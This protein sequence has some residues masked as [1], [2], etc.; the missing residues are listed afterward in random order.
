MKRMRRVLVIAL[1][2]MLAP[3]A[4]S[5][6]KYQAAM[7]SLNLTAEQRDLLMEMIANQEAADSVA[8]NR[9]HYSVYV[10]TRSY[11]DHIYV[12]WAPDEYVPWRILNYWGYSVVRIHQTKKDLVV[13][14]LATVK[15]LTLE[16]FMEAYEVNDTLAAAA[17]QIIYGKRTEFGNTEAH[18]GS[19]GSIVELMEEQQMVYSYAMLIAEKRRDIAVSMALAF[20]DRTA[21]PKQEYD[22]VVVPLVPDSIIPVDRY[23][24]TAGPLGS[25]KPEKLRTE[26]TDS[27]KAPANVQLYWPRRQEYTAFDIERRYVSR[28]GEW[29]KLNDKPYIMMQQPEA[30]ETGYN[31]YVDERV[32]PGSYEYRI[33]GY[34]MFGDLTAPCEPH[35]VEMPDLIPPSAPLLEFIEIVRDPDSDHID[36]LLHIVKD[37]IEE[38]LVGYIPFYQ[39]PNYKDRINIDI[40]DSVAQ[41]LN[42]DQ[43][44]LLNEGMMIPLVKNPVA[45]GDTIIKVDV[46]GLESG[47]LVIAATDTA[48]NMTISMPLPIHIHDL[49]PPAPPT[50]LRAAMDMSGL[51]MMNWRPSTSV[52]IEGYEIY[53]ANDLDHP[54][55]QHPGFYSADTMFVDT[56]SMKTAEPY[57]YYYVKARDYAGNGSVPSDTLQVERLTIVPPSVCRIDTLWMTP[58]TVNMKWYPA[59]EPDIL[60]YNVFRRMEGEQD[61]QLTRVL[62]PDSIAD[63]RLT[64]VDSPEP[65]MTKRYYYAIETINRS[66]LSSGM[67]YATSFLFK[68]EVV[69]PIEIKLFSNFNE[70][71]KKAQL[72]W[73]IKGLTEAV[74]KDAYLVI[75]RKRPEDEFFRHFK[76]VSVHDRYTV[77]NALRP[78]QEAQYE[79]RLRTNEGRF[80]PYSNRVMIKNTEKVEE[81]NGERNSNF[82]VQESESL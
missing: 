67:S 50:R 14:T 54:F 80:S 64:I 52:D 36:A 35:R 13:D 28:G 37:S 51:M 2:V 31:I 78:G 29:V 32:H 61:W 70:E 74:A 62:T 76:S 11:D 1:A 77:D 65:H 57:R 48:L 53:W 71:T 33:K 40:P 30:H 66:G 59:S 24:A 25:W 47:T 12:R 69:L 43:R 55:A 79:M 44:R 46:T 73:E 60:C 15:P 16:Q 23:V 75:F 5:A 10:T 39:N 49:M 4:L 18:P 72:A 27:I 68:G 42:D 34:D 6:Q 17:A 38:D 9:H 21:K 19:M 58:K 20:E 41:Q 22:Y 82:E 63:G 56:L 26:I 7:D 45:P 3:M 8:A 81:V